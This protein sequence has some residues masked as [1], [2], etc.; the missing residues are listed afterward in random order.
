MGNAAASS[1]ATFT[2]DNGGRETSRLYG[3][4]IETTRAY[5]ADNTLTSIAAANVETL[6][7]TYD[8]NKNPTR[9]RTLSALNISS[10]FAGHGS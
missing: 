8:E 9:T 3:N 4:G 1:I 7:Y 10:R 5:Q 6:S 2:Y